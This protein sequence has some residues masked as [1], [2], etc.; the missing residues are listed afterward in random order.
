MVGYLDDP[1]SYDGHIRFPQTL[2]KDQMDQPNIKFRRALTN[3]DLRKPPPIVSYTLIIDF[4]GTAGMV[5]NDIYGYRVAE[6]RDGY[7]LLK[8]KNLTATGVVD[9]AFV[10]KTSDSQILSIIPPIDP[11]YGA[12]VEGGRIRI[13][14]DKFEAFF[15]LS[16]KNYQPRK[17]ILIQT[18]GEYDVP[19]GLCYE[20]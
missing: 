6:F 15:S 10:P 14:K 12:K 7:S 3:F 19:E 13:Q 4:N 9:M 11:E 2:Q 16:A 5:W 18:D 1:K 17:E 8:G 20:F